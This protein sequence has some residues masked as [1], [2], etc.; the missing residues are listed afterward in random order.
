LVNVEMLAPGD[1]VVCGAS[2]SDDAAVYH[3]TAIASTWV[4]E[5]VAIRTQDEV[6]RCTEDH[7]V[8]VIGRG[9]VKA[10]QLDPSDLLRC[11]EGG[12]VRVLSIE[13]RRLERAIRVYNIVVDGG[14]TYHVGKRG[15]LVHNKSI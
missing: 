4:R 15:L 1:E 8:W 3:V 7:P 11:I 2:G 6:V 10:G 9:W 5:I 13:R 14:H 12:S